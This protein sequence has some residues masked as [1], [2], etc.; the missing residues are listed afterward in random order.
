MPRAV[1]H[2]CQCPACRSDAEAHAAARALHHQINLFVSRLDE[3]QR[4]WYVALESRRLGHGGERLMA[5]ITGIS[6]KTIRRGRRELEAELADRPVD[7]IRH[8]GGGRHAAEIDDPELEST[9]EQLLA[10]ETAGNPQGRGKY[11]RSS[12]RQLSDRLVQHGH[13]A[14]RDTVG[15]L[16]R[17]L[18]Y[19]LRVNARRKEARSSPPERDSQFNYIQQQKRDFLATGEPVISVDTKK[20][21]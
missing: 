10:P 4:R 6:E 21:S 17:K 8:V 1:I 18:G 3:Q 7:R 5:Q 11:K 16:A 20:R 9:L 14:S 12:L 13:P 19:S 2:D 15:R